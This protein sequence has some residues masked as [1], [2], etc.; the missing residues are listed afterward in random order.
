MIK[1]LHSIQHTQTHYSFLNHNANKIVLLYHYIISK[2]LKFMIIFNTH[3]IRN[4][5]INL[6]HSSSC[7]FVCKFYSFLL[8]KSKKNCFVLSLFLF[9]PKIIG[10]E[11]NEKEVATPIF[12]NI[13]SPKNIHSLSLFPAIYILHMIYLIGSLSIYL[14]IQQSIY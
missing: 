10:G 11:R 13:Y 5:I 7:T 6:I 3:G 8:N 14:A 12:N 9:P 4:Y 2:L 1:P